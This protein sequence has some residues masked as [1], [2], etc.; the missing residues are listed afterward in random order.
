MTMR[1]RLRMAFEFARSV[2]PRPSPSR[3]ALFADAALA[4]LI[5]LAVRRTLHGGGNSFGLLI[6][7]ALLAARRRFPLTACLLLS[8]EVLATRYNAKPLALGIVVFAGYSA[9]VH[10]PFRGAAFVTVPW[11]W[12][13]RGHL[14]LG[15]HRAADPGVAGVDRDRGIRHACCRRTRPDARRT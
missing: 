13:D 5:V 6:A 1:R 2:E 11:L 14:P 10:S 9:V 3:W 4:V 7:G 15:N 8:I 12:V